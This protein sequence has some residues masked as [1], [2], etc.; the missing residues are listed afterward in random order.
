MI[1]LDSAATTPVKSEVFEAM[2][3]YLTD[4]FGNPGSSHVF[5][6]EARE[7]VEKARE[8]VAA[9]FGGKAENVVFTSSGSEANN[10]AIL[11]CADY[12]ESIGKKHIIT[13]PAEHDSVLK[14]VEYL[15]IK[16]GFD[17]T[18]LPVTE[19][20]NVDYESVRAS[21]RDDTGLLAL[22]YVNNETGSDNPVT[23]VGRLCQEKSIIFVCDCVQAAGFYS[24][25][26]DIFTAD[27]KTIS[28]HKIHAPKGV[29]AVYI[30]NLESKKDI[31]TP[32][33]HGGNGQEFGLRAGTENVPCIV[34]L[35]KAC[36]IA[37]D[38]RIDNMLK[39]SHFNTLLQS[40]LLDFAYYTGLEDSVHINSCAGKIVNVTF[41]TVD[42]ESLILMLSNGGIFL[43]SGAACSSNASE[44]SHVL[45]A[46]GLTED[47]ARNSVRISLHENLS[48]DDIIYAASQIIK[49]VEWFVT[50]RIANIFCET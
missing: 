32:I 44:P 19:A 45:L 2:K 21:V 35:G 38:E 36:E 9:L 31:I 3:P 49:A 13:S 23:D 33:I 16:R 7:A 11:G 41:D 39:I 15:R 47:Q 26:E 48:N 30:R 50:Y 22:M 6:R 37:L 14:A 20:A 46:T 34:A 4:D 25:D 27:F 17:I 42:S 43:S 28:G 18:Y 12:L 5:G 1:Y 29:G 40:K 24:I 10:L 8:Q